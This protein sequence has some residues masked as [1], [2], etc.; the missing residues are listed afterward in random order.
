MISFFFPFCLSNKYSFHISS[1]NLI[2]MLK[3]PTNCFVNFV[4]FH[5]ISLFSILIKISPGDIKIL[6]CHYLHAFSHLESSNH[7]VLLVFGKSKT[8]MFFI[9]ILKCFIELDS[10]VSLFPVH[11]FW[12]G[13][14]IFECQVTVSCSVS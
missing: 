1:K 12:Y 10:I 2:H 5:T 14:N 7:W 13:L 8:F 4:H 3:I 9:D 6:G 11:A